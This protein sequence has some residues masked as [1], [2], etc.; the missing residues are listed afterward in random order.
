M[1]A[2]VIRETDP[3]T[4]SEAVYV[5]SAG[6]IIA[7]PTETCYGLLADATNS[8]AVARIFSIKGRPKSKALS[9]FV[10]DERELSQNAIMTVKAR[11][12]A[13]KY[14]PGPLT[15]VLKKRKPFRLSRLLSAGNTV[16]FRI[17][18]HPF[19]AGLLFNYRKPITA[20]SANISGD[21]E[22]H[23]F[24]E[25]FRHFGRS[26]DLIIDGG[27]LLP[28]PPSTVVDCSG[29]GI[30]IIRKGAIKLKIN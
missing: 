3:T 28:G 11:T 30:Q 20:T 13:K 29:K 17:S 18:A 16:A 15:L 27:N 14:L 7:A 19:I 23:S 6:G 24:K 25:A 12:L 1:G 21:K 10:F 9:V 26:V 22:I 2:R 4:L 8:K 5:L